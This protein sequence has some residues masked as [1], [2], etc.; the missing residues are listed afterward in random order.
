MLCCY[1]PLKYSC[2]CVVYL[3]TCLSFISII[4]SFKFMSYLRMRPLCFTCLAL[5]AL[6]AAG[7]SEPPSLLIL[8]SRPRLVKLYPSYL[9]VLPVSLP[10]LE[11]TSVFWLLVGLLASLW[12]SL[13]ARLC[14]PP[15]M[16]VLCCFLRVLVVYL[17]PMLAT[18]LPSACSRS[19]WSSSEW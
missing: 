10:K 2:P 1:F 3:Y 14:G 6:L 13:L 11:F 4:L 17:E 19:S 7:I 8:E 16:L 18:S 9:I 5:E 15:R 12:A